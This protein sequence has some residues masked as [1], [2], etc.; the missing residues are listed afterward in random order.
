MDD[1]KLAQLGN[2]EAAKRLTET[3][4]F[5]ASGDLALCRCPFC[6]SENVVYERYLHAAGY[7]WRVVCMSCMASIDPGYAQQRSTVQQLWNTRAPIL[8]AEEMERLEGME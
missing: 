4:Y 5:K 7:R 3:G 8:S 6:G 1:I 2:K